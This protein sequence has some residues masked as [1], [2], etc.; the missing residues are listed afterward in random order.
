[1]DVR[2]GNILIGDDQTDGQIIVQV[3]DI[4]KRTAR[5]IEALAYCL[6]ETVQIPV[7][8]YSTS[9]ADVVYPALSLQFERWFRFDSLLSDGRQVHEMVNSGRKTLLTIVDILQPHF[10][11]IDSP[12]A[13]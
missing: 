3:S 4:H 2:F 11:H 5:C 8:T 9:E 7:L 12:S 6:V 1:M 10:K 13:L